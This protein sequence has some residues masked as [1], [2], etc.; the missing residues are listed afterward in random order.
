MKGRD[1]EKHKEGSGEA[2]KGIRSD[3]FAA[4]IAETKAET[5][6]GHNIPLTSNFKP[7]S[8]SS[9]ELLWPHRIPRLSRS[10]ASVST[11][12][13]RE[14]AYRSNLFWKNEGKKY[15]MLKAEEPR[16]HLCHASR[17]GNKFIVEM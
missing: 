6:A 14:R 13:K 8:R 2:G 7:I 10:S 15:A 12:S 16:A 11:S 1:E 9:T 4:R 5:K 3:G 17:H